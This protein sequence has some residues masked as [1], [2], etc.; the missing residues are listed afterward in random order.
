ME[1]VGNNKSFEK[2]EITTSRVSTFGWV[3]IVVYLWGIPVPFFQ[4]LPHRFPK[5]AFVENEPL[6]NII[7]VC[8]PTPPVDKNIYINYC[9]KTFL[10]G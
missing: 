9:N 6:I 3:K 7:A 5:Q 1:I 4:Q 8:F 2:T 10:S